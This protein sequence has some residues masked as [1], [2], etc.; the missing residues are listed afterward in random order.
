MDQLSVPT[1]GAGDSDAA[2]RCWWDS[3]DQRPTTKAGGYGE[4]GEQ[5]EQLS[6]PGSA[7]QRAARRGHGARSRADAAWINQELPPPG[8]GQ[9]VTEGEDALGWVQ[10]GKQSGGI[11]PTQPSPAAQHQH[12][13]GSTPPPRDCQLTNYGQGHLKTWPLQHRGC[14]EREGRLEDTGTLSD[15]LMATEG[16][17]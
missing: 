10:G 11:V 5:G 6:I 7:A 2:T 13:Q 4:Q 14:K 12:T 3:E 15:P 16:V 17:G 1:G 8:W 9:A